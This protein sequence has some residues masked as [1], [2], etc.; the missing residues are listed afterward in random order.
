MFIQLFRYTLVG[1][2]AFLLDFGSLFVFTEYFHFY[3]LVSAAIAFTLGLITN[4]IL[5]VTWVFEKR[6]VQSRWK[7]FAIF[8]LIGIIGLL[9]NELMLWFFTE[10]VRLHY[11]M[12][13]IISAGIVYFWNFFARKFSLFS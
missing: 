7:E 10:I 1:G 8:T 13:K 4:Y 12:S 11:L 3:Y 5:S 9:S 6:S 2:L